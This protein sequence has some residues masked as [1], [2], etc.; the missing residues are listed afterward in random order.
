MKTSARN[1][2]RGT[3]TKLEIG[4]TNAEVT[5]EIAPDLT[6]VSNITAES[7]RTLQLELGKTAYVIVKASSVMVGVD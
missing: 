4:V 3:I 6:I 5:I 2:L 1:V 7:A